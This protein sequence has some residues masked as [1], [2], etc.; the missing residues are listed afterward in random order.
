MESRPFQNLLSTLLLLLLLPFLLA[1]AASPCNWTGVTCN[2]TRRGGRL[3]GTIPPT[4][5]TLFK[6]SSLD[7][8]STIPV[9]LGRL[10]NLVF[11]KL[12]NNFL[13]VPRSF[14]N[15]RNLTDHLVVSYNNFEGPTPRSLRNCSSLIRFS[16]E[17][18]KN[19]SMLVSL[20][21]LDL[22]NNKLSGEVPKDIGKLSNL[23]ILDLSKNNLSG[24]VPEKLGDIPSQISKLGPLPDSQFI[25][26][27]PI[28]W[29]AH[30][31]AKH[32][33]VILLA[34]LPVLGTLLLLFLFGGATILLLRRRNSTV[35]N[36]SQKMEG[37]VLPN[38]K[39]VA[40][41]RI[42]PLETENQLHEP[43][44]LN[45]IQALTGIRHRN[46]VKLYG[47]CST[48]QHKLLVYEYMEREFK[49]CVSDFGIAR[50]VRPDSS[51]W[52]MLAGTRGYVAP[53]L[54]Y[55]MRVT[56]K[57]DVYSFGVVTLEV[58]MGE[59]PGDLISTLA[60]SNGENT[61]LKDIL[62]PRLS[63]PT[64][65]VADEVAMLVMIARQCLDGNPQ[66]RPTML[67]VTHNW[68]LS[69]THLSLDFYTTKLCHLRQIQK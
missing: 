35:Q 52:S 66:S 47:F 34:T 28:E 39:I 53:E 64:A 6:L 57:C 11:L 26:N 15:L 43:H 48:A 16:G 51:N 4:I 7:L 29:F 10:R 62:D 69:R 24:S 1:M 38:G 42:K 67:H 30:N 12:S 22:S 45:E 55:T 27:S 40:V 32:R 56:E 19:A 5:A 20:Y 23:E 2:V 36:A 59:H 9:E 14:D 21:Q 68:L 8:T 61:L 25:R 17:I 58:L 18:P 41:K 65:Q 49:A 63:L 31:E 60:S 44:F 13:A 33:K 50:L 54:A 3:N 46:I 37:A